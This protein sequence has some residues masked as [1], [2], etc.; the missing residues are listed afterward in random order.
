MTSGLQSADKLCENK[1]LLS[2]G[3]LC[4]WCHVVKWMTTWFRARVPWAGRCCFKPLYIDSTKTLYIT[5]P[6][7]HGV[8]ESDFRLHEPHGKMCLY[9][10]RNALQLYP[11]CV[12]VWGDLYWTLKVTA[13]SKI[14]FCI[15]SSLPCGPCDLSQ[16]LSLWAFTGHER[17]TT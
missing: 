9:P 5:G 11:M 1:F 16:I 6:F 7:K 3:L 14:W 15:S 12:C 17:N 13:C 4:H 10:H 8:F 2:Y